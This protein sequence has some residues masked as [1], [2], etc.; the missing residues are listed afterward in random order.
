MEKLNVVENP[1]E[2]CLNGKSELK[3]IRKLFRDWILSTQ[4]T[5]TD[6]DIETVIDFFAQKTK[7]D[8]NDFVYSTL[9]TLSRMCQD[10]NQP[11][12][13]NMYNKI[14]NHVE[15]IFKSKHNGKSLYL[16][17]NFLKSQ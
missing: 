16:S 12:W 15:N 10:A 7:N 5:P 11:Y 13:S 6:D 2:I 4:D 17:F 8:E 1:V 14:V 3:D 9:K